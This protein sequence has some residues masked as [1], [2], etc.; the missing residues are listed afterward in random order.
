MPTFHWCVV[1]KIIC[2]EHSGIDE[3]YRVP[4]P[5]SLGFVMREVDFLSQAMSIFE[6]IDKKMSQV[7]TLVSASPTLLGFLEPVVGDRHHTSRTRHTSSFPLFSIASS[8]RP[9]IHRENTVP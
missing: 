8:P 7:T 2:L 6:R 5:H 4:V 3:V 9:H 1:P